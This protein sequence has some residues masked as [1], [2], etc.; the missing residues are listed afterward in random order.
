MGQVQITAGELLW[1]KKIAYQLLR[2]LPACVRVEDLIQAG[3]LGLIEAH[4]RFDE[5]QNTSLN[6]F[7]NLRVRGAMFD[8]LR[9]SGWASR[10]MQQHAKVLSETERHCANQ[11]KRTATQQELAAYLQI[12]PEQLHQIVLHGAGIH[13]NSFEE[14]SVWD[15]GEE[16]MHQLAQLEQEEHARYLGAGIE[17]LPLKEAFVVR[18]HYQQGY[19]FKDIAE[20]LGVSDAR[21]SQLHHQA[22]RALRAYWSDRTNGIAQ[23]EAA[24]EEDFIKDG[25]LSC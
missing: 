22:L 15:V 4:Q 10:S 3:C 2:N 6:N 8:E 20:R 12:T 9:R 7:A 11:H 24:E 1:V 17:G 19:T 23:D 13:V 16:N 21:V 5:K 18:L 14:G 25:P